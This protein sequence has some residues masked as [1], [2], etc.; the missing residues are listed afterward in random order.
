[1]AMSPTHDIRHQGDVPAEER[2]RTVSPLLWALL[3]L[4]LIAA[5]AWWW[6][7]NSS[8][9]PETVAAPPAPPTASEVIP[10]PA[11]PKQPSMVKQEPQRSAPVVR[12]RD[13]RPL[14]GNPL[15]VYP[16]RA[17]RAG[18]EGSVVARVSIDARGHVDDVEIIERK[19]TRDRE[20]DRAVIDAVRGWRFEPAI[21]N[22][23]AV[24]STVQLP[25]DF[26]AQQ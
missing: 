8:E 10:A 1:M 11:Q 18:I 9:R 19:G 3:I 7:R 2:E 14:G 24:A 6:I 26:K 25:V 16:S 5:P 20:L 4:L 23:H 15:P 22:G 21:R 12:N 17:L 13:A